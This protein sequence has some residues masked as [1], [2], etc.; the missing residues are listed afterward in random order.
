MTESAA[1]TNSDVAEQVYAT[2]GDAL[3]AARLTLADPAA[4]PTE[5]AGALWALGRAAYYANRVSDAVRLLRDAVPLVGDPE[6]LTEIL[7]T[8]A[9]ALSKDGR[10]EEAL[11]MLADPSLELAPR[12]RGQLRNQRGIILA[13]VNRLPEALE[14]TEEALALLRAAGERS[15]EARTLVN[16]GAI[17]S[18][19]GRLD[20]AERWYEEA[21]DC[22]VATGQHVV[23]AG[24]E[25]N[26]GYVASRRGRYAEALD[27]YSRARTSFGRLGG[28]DLLVAVLEID[29]ARTLLDV[30]LAVDASQ[31]AERAVRSAASGGNQML[32]TQARLLRAEALTALDDRRHAEL[33]VRRGAEL[34]GRLGQTAWYLRA[35]HLAAELDITLP[36]EGA[37]DGAALGEID[38]FLVAGWAREALE[39][40][41]SRA[42]QMGQ[43]QPDRA[44]AL[45]SV[46]A[47]RTAGLDVDPLDRAHA[48]LLLAGFDGDPTRAARAFDD[49]LAAI[50]AQRALI[51]SVELRATILHRLA[52]I[53]DDALA[54]ALESPDA[55]HEVLGVLE[56]VRSMIVAPGGD[57]GGAPVVQAALARL[58]DARVALDE[59]KLG[60]GDVGA[61]ATTV[62]SLEREVL[63]HR[64]AAGG[65]QPSPGATM[66]A[67][68]ADVP[69]GSAYITYAIRL[70]LLV[71]VVRR[72]ERSE[73]HHLG[74]LDAI[75]GA[76]RSQRL[77]LQHL[78][79]ERFS[80]S[81]SDLARLQRASATLDEVLVRPLGAGAAERVVLT[82]PI[83]LGDITWSAL[84]SLVDRP[85]TVVPC[86]ASW[87]ADADAPR[88]RRY[89]FLGGPGLQAAADELRRIGDIWRRPDAVVVAASCERA[90]AALLRA[91]LLHVAAHGTFRLDNPFFSSLEFT[92]GSLT[93]LEMVDL[94]RAPAVVVLASCDAGSGAAAG[95]RG[96]P[97]VVG[98][99]AELRHIGAR[100]VVAPP[101][102]VNDRAAAEYTVG[103]HT[104]LAAGRSI[105][106]AVVRTRLRG[107]ASSDPT[108][109]AAAH[110]FTVFGDAGTRH[111][112]VP[113]DDG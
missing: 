62:R 1:T 45:L 105:D 22:T 49:A 9:P 91:D 54:S 71:A 30:G 67:R 51:G 84:P 3:D 58:R 42:R 11:A 110:A 39:T 109:V 23:A 48:S 89:S 113:R 63:D 31:A 72:G 80:G 57:L 17:T 47:E 82:P 56:R 34:A 21:R 97:A 102:V 37:S 73:L 53:C 6:M 5:R 112:I 69:E 96:S 59:A 14:Q 64:R 76:M 88:V 79:D 78:A 92:D 27:W 25:G 2:P 107:A 111:P 7:L 86:L 50:D 70:G 77:A 93:V 61:A 41:V 104:E 90:G 99:A 65:N 108:V 12:F 4:T 101:V 103:L 8:L 24:I 100:V 20:E 15:Q 38:A 81:G 32:E 55:A 44:R 66:P 52:P 40:A 85:L 16:L 87:A 13:E 33:E 26:L 36:D 83:A 60:G 46:A 94:G 28:V 106:D 10:P 98:T 18:M 43:A 95:G 19:M 68:H 75:V 35:L 74:P 29:H